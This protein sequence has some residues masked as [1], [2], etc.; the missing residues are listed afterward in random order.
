MAVVTATV[1]RGSGGRRGSRR[2][3]RAAVESSRHWLRPLDR[4]TLVVSQYYQPPLKPGMNFISQFTCPVASWHAINSAYMVDPAVVVCFELLH[5]IAPAARVNMYPDVN[6]VLS[7]AK[8]ESE[9]PT[10]WSDSAFL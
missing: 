4:I 5:E 9:Y 10:I 7:F 3:R 6:F 2:G 8:S 1:L